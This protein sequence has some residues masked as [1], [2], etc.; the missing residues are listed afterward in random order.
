MTD[1]T[2]AHDGAAGRILVD[3]RSEPVRRALDPTAWMVLEELALAGGGAGP[4]AG[5]AGTV[6]QT[7]VRRLADVLG[8]SKD[9]V[10][11]AVRRLTAAG[12]V[13]RID[14]R[15]TA[16]GRFGHA[17]YEVD[18]AAA[19]LAAVS[20]D[21][22]AGALDQH[23]QMGSASALPDVRSP[24]SDRRHATSSRPRHDPAQLSLLDQ[25]VPP[26]QPTTATEPPAST[27]TDP[28]HQPSGPPKPSVPT[29]RTNE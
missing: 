15:Q 13:R 29:T 2:K 8:L 1:H 28:T 18:L 23:P 19:G 21:A 11:A 20:H 16:S 24:G 3:R 7:S 5:G 17:R 25:P 6:S 12:L 14:E 4:G 9:T 26:I 22:G 10:A 27:N